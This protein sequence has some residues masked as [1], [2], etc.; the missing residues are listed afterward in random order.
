MF[1]VYL[2]VHSAMNNIVVCP[3]RPKIGINC[4]G[5]V[6][7]IGSLSTVCVDAGPSIGEWSWESVRVRLAWLVGGFGAKQSCLALTISYNNPL[8]L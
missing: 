2:Y 4:H 3:V 7:K 5:T 8:A 6:Q 1:L